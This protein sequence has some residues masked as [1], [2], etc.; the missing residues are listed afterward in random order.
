MTTLAPL[1]YQTEA[2]LQE[3]DKTTNASEWGAIY[4]NYLNLYRDEY[5]NHNVYR[6]L[7]MEWQLYKENK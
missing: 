3:M 6:T 2:M 1:H 5:P 4:Q 7:T